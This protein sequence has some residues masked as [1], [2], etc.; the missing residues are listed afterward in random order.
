MQNQYNPSLQFGR[1]VT[2]VTTRKK[3]HC[4]VFVTNAGG[5][6]VHKTKGTN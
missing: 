5:G 2:I 6:K 3:K 4:K 1:K